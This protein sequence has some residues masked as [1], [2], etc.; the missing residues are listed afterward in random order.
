MLAC[1]SLRS[2]VNQL[3]TLRETCCAYPPWLSKVEDVVSDPGLDSLSAERPQNALG[4]SLSECRFE[5]G[6]L[7]NLPKDAAIPDE[8]L[9]CSQLL[10]CFLERE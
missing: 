3:R 10:K 7:K 9:V 6:H 5:Y 8:C 2:F 4:K 1:K